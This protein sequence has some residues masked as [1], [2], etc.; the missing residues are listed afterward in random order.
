[1]KLGL[2]LV[3]GS[4]V[5]IADRAG[6]TVRLDGDGLPADPLAVLTDPALKSKAEAALRTAKGTPGK[7]DYLAPL[8]NLNRIFCVGLNYVDHVAESPYKNRTEHPVFFIRVASGVVPHEA[9]LVRPGVSEQL[10]WEGELAVVIG[11]E[12]RAI[13]EEDALDHVAAYTLF[14]DGS[15]RDWQFDEG[16]RQWTLGKNFDDS[17]SIGPMLV[18]A[19]ELP[20][21]AKGLALETRIN[22]KAYQKANTDDLIFSIAQVIARLSI[23]IKLLPG[24]VIATGTP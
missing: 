5:L 7:L 12:G 21:G 15:I 23:A 6:E 1:M 17:G 4:P 20:K 19:D 13:R 10:D 24:D 22:G 18:S 16:P 8:K 14:N 3:G 2:A 11:R 9:P